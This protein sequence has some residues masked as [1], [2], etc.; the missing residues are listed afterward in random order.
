MLI[1]VTADDVRAGRRRHPCLC[2]VALAARRATGTTVFV[3]RADILVGPGQHFIRHPLPADLA[4]HIAAYDR[5]G[6]MRPFT[7][8]LP[9]ATPRP[10]ESAASPPTAA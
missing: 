9:P 3:T 5:T 10:S 4:E 2:P 6:V 8:D 1:D 7:F